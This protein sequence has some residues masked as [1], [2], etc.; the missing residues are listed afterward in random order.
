MANSGQRLIDPKVSFN[1]VDLPFVVPNSVKGMFG[2]EKTV[3]AA[4]YGQ[5]QVT[6]TGQNNETN[7]SE[8][9]L[10]IHN[11]PQAIAFY[12]QFQNVQDAQ[13]RMLGATPTGE[14]VNIIIT[15]ASMTSKLEFAFS[16][17]GKI[18]LKFMGNPAVFV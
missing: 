13:L 15:G 3:D 10:E 6:V 7:L 14:S 4:R 9:E 17:D 5:S 18:P 12:A 11:T 16:H 1:G 2:N 8:V